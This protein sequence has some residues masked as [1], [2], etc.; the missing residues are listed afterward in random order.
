MQSTNNF[1]NGSI[2]DTT[3]TTTQHPI[4]KDSN[5]NVTESPGFMKE[6]EI[7]K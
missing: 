4:L 3:T 2:N 1:Y 6:E 5:L 7:L